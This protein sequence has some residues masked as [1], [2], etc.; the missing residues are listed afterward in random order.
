[1]N[2]TKLKVLSVDDSPT[3]FSHL[4]YVLKDLSYIDWVGHAF[5]ISCGKAM[6]TTLNP[7]VVLL[8]IMVEDESGFDLLKHLKEKYPN[9]KVF[10][11]SNLADSIYNK[12]SIKMGASHYIDKSFEFHTIEDLLEIEYYNRNMKSLQN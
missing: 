8:D 7:D 4:E 3:I 10:M 12:K 1:M 11:L 5:K 9:I 2:P 6:A